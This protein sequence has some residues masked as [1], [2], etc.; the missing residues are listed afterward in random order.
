LERR[1]RR[2][3]YVAGKRGQFL[4]MHLKNMSMFN[5]E[6]RDWFTRED[7]NVKVFYAPC[8]FGQSDKLQEKDWIQ[9]HP[10]KNFSRTSFQRTI[11][12]LNPGNKVL[13]DAPLA[14][15][16]QFK[17]PAKQ[18]K[19]HIALRAELNTSTA[20][21]ETPVYEVDI[22]PNVKNVYSK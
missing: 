19:V 2:S 4:E 1:I 14:F 9:V 13:V 12:T 10:D 8:Q 5:I 18:A 17:I 22:V 15:L 11:L 16:E 20:R 7:Y 6:I 21:S 3:E